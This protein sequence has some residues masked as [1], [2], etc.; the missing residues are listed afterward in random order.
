MQ[1]RIDSEPRTPGYVAVVNS[2]ASRLLGAGVPMGPNALITIRGRKSG[3]ARTTPV[4][5]VAVDGRRWIQG[6]WGETNWVKNLRASGEATLKVGRRTESVQAVELSREDAVA[7]F[8]DVL[9]P[10]VR[11]IPFGRWIT[12]KMLKSPEFLSDPDAAAE[13]HPV[14]ELHPA[15]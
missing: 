2:L 11:R 10:Y 14:F 12:G 13:R 8:H 4:T 6:A 5:L 9:G 15:A 3:L 7:F 1:P